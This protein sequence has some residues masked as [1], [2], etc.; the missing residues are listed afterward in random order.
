MLLDTPAQQLAS[1]GVVSIAGFAPTTQGKD[2]RS[3]KTL[4]A[5]LDA[6]HPTSLQEV[7]R[8][9][10]DYRHHYNTKRRHQGLVKG[11][12]HLTPQQAWEAFV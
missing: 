8:F 3:H 11:R 10:V 4:T 1:L 9:L 2:E 6:R 12:F 5:F 7:T